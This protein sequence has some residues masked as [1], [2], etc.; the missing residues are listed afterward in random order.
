MTTKIVTTPRVAHS[1][2]RMRLVIARASAGAARA[3]ERTAPPECGRLVEILF[4][5]QQL[6]VLGDAVG[7]CGRA[8]LDLTAVGR[9]GEIG[10]G[11]VFAL[12]RAMRH[13]RRVTGSMRH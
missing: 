1:I 8:G 7:T 13:D 12:T 6:V 4:D 11:G 5:A 9:D 10:D 2:R 3:G